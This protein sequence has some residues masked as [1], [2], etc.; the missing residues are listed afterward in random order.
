MEFQSKK[1]FSS[2]PLSE[3]CFRT[4]FPFLLVSNRLFIVFG[5]FTT[6]FILLSGIVLICWFHHSQVLVIYSLKLYTLHVLV[7]FVICLLDPVSTVYAMINLQ[8][9]CKFIFLCLVFAVCITRLNY[10]NTCQILSQLLVNRL[11]YFQ[12]LGEY[13]L[14]IILYTAI[15]RFPPVRL[16]HVKVSDKKPE[17]HLLSLSKILL[18]LSSEYTYNLTYL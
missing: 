10:F 13:V 8:S 12:K 6:C 17:N 3:A 15:A 7:V 5:S 18:L 2:Y 4:V 1:P 14:L 16:H 9:F 11:R